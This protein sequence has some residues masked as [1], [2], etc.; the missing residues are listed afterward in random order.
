MSL[1]NDITINHSIGSN[2][3]LFLGIYSSTEAFVFVLSTHLSS[4]L[5]FTIQFGLIQLKNLKNGKT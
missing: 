4:S 2:A 5:Y 1:P 3:A